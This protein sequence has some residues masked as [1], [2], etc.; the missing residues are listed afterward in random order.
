LFD[1]GRGATIRLTQLGIP[2]ASVHKVFLTHLHSDH[3]IALPDLFL[4]APAGFTGRKV[5]LEVWGPG[6]THDMMEHMQRAFAF[7]IHVRR[8]EERWP[9]D[10]L[11]VISHDI[12]QG[13]VFENDGLK[14]TA[15]LVDHGP[16]KPA[17]GYRVDY[18]G[19]SVAL[20]GDTRPSEN[21]IK[22]AQGACSSMKRVLF[23]LSAE[24]TSRRSLIGIEESAEARP[25]L[26]TSRHLDRR[27]ARDQAIANALV[28]SFGVVVLDVIRHGAAEVPR[29]D[30]N[31][32]VQAFFFDRPHEAL[33]VRVRIRRAR[34]GQHDADAGVT[35]S[36]PHVLAPLPISIADQDVW[37]RH[38][39]GVGHR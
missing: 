26:H 15:F 24:L 13:T 33:R 10:G 25:T 9:K 14:I 18:R 6:G 3:V 19:H 35:E 23:H 17:F 20:S 39:T 36:T 27:R 34:R 2:I 12:E 5:P 4:T 22:H 37:W 16:V 11:S 32:A 1:C 21:L 28:I 38:C 7:D 29:P 30:R 8:D 31:Q